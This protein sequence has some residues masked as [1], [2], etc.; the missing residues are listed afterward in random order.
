MASKLRAADGSR[1][2]V[3]VSVEHYSTAAAAASR[4]HP[5]SKL[6][7]EDDGTRY[8]GTPLETAGSLRAAHEGDVLD[9][10]DMQEVGS[11]CQEVHEEDKRA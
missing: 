3:V 4:Q 9:I 1:S 5:P 6:S 2:L 7:T 10:L 8:H 11:S